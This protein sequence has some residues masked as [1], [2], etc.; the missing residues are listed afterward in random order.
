MTEHQA[1]IAEIALLTFIILAV[2][3]LSSALGLFA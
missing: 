1:A 3:W 2:W